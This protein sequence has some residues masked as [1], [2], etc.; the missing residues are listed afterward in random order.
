MKRQPNSPW[1]RD[2]FR[3]GEPKSLAGKIHKAR[4]E[5]PEWTYKQ[6]ADS[7]GCAISTVG[8]VLSRC[9][10]YGHGTK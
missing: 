8:C 7:V 3:V 2:G 10:F 6:I 4:R 9:G 1:G 5:H